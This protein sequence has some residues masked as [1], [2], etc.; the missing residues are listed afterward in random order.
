M[1]KREPV[2]QRRPPTRQPR[3]TI[4]IV[5]GADRTEADYLKGLRDHVKAATVTMKIVA[6]PGAPDQLVEHARGFA[7]RDLYDEIW[8]VTDVDHYERE[9]GKVT[10]AVELAAKEGIDVA[11]SNPCFEI[12]LLLHR[13]SC[14]SPCRDC[15]AVLRKLRK[16]LP[17][18]DKSGL[19]FNDFAGGLDEARARAERLEPTGR[20]HS[21]N[22]STSVWRLVNAI[23]EQQ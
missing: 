6:K 3:R 9:G 11:V 13:E 2:R 8:C 18:Y 7:D 22:P 4:L 5:V 19:R 23:L 1:P 14:S 21:R 15:D 17:A 10:L 16:A 12:W 20:D